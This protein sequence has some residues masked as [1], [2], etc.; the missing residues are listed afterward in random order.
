MSINTEIYGAESNWK[1]F[2]LTNSAAEVPY[3][4]KVGNFGTTG[5][6]VYTSSAYLLGTWSNGHIQGKTPLNTV[7]DLSPAFMGVDR[8]CAMTQQYWYQPSYPSRSFTNPRDST[9]ISMLWDIAYNYNSNLN[10]Y[11]GLPRFNIDDT[12]T[13]QT[14]RPWS[15]NIDNVRSTT[16]T[17]SSQGTYKYVCSNDAAITP[18]VGDFDVKKLV[19]YPIIYAF[20]TSST[21]WANVIPSKSYSDGGVGVYHM[22]FDAYIKG[23]NTVYGET[24]YNY[25]THPYIAGIGI[26]VRVQSVADSKID[27][28]ISARTTPL[29][30]IRPRIIQDSG[31][32]TYTNADGFDVSCKYACYSSNVYNGNYTRYWNPTL[33]TTSTISASLYVGCLG[34]WGS[35]YYISDSGS[36][37][38]KYIYSVFGDKWHIHTSATARNPIVEA[39]IGTDWTDIEDFKTWVMS[40]MAY[41]GVFFTTGSYNAEHLTLDDPEMYLGVLDDNY[42]S[43]GAYTHGSDNRNQKQWKWENPFNETTYKPTPQ[44]DDT[45]PNTYIDEMRGRDTFSFSGFTSLYAMT[46]A[47]VNVMRNILSYLPKYLDDHSLDEYQQYIYNNF[48]NGNP[49]DNILSLKWYP[50][51]LREYVTITAASLEN[52]QISNFVMAYN[53]TGAVTITATGYKSITPNTLITLKLGYGTILEHYHSFMDYEPYTHAEMYLPFCNAVE[54]DLKIAMNHDLYV[55]YKVDIKTGSCTALITLDGYNGAVLATSHGTIGID[56]PVS[57]IQTGD[58]QNAIYQGIA[59]LKNAQINSGINAIGKAASITMSAVGAISN[60]IGGLVGTAT[61]AITAG[62]SFGRDAQNVKSAQYELNSAAIPYRVVGSAS[63]GDGELMYMY[64]AILISKPKFIAGYN[65]ENYAH[66]VGFACIETQSLGNFS[67]LTVAASIDTTGISATESEKN[68]IAQLLQSG[69]YL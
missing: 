43:H 13:S 65:A 29:S 8:G 2:T 33:N 69:I 52:V 40:Q 44:E 53:P 39:H 55:A 38:G 16:Q 11:N 3:A 26:G 35:S 20:R 25:E 64:P 30:G 28:T 57:G 37:A 66:T 24:K 42:V 6:T 68:E 46:P 58:Y 50:F 5:Q 22:D 36:S 56:I 61:T 45:D 62:L 32:Y 4:V 10:A 27:G 48:L 9:V 19:F 49:I 51:D 63:A 54:I 34:G 17:S 41:L 31:I 15:Y 12:S 60:P 18:I 14:E 7:P 67:G 59:N 1:S 23:T 47:D 21:T